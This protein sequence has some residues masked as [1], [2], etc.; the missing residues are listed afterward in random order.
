MSGA[1]TGKKVFVS[2]CHRQGEWVVGSLVPCLRA[3]GVEVWIDVERFKA[4][5]TVI[6]QMDA[7]Q[8]RAEQSLLVFSPDYLAS[9]YCRHEMARAIERDPAFEQG[10]TIPVLVQSCSLPDEIKKPQPLWVDLT[11][12]W[13][14]PNWK[15]L[16][17]ATGAEL[18]CPAARWLETRDELADL[19]RR[20]CSVNFVVP[21]RDAHA[22]RPRWRELLR[23]LEKDRFADL[24]CVDLERGAAA[25]R[26]GLVEMILEATGN[27]QAVP[28]KPHDLGILDRAL[29]K[30]GN[31]A[32]LALIHFDYAVQR[33]DEYGVD[34]FSA[35]RSL[36]EDGHIALMV[37]SC[38]PFMELLPRDHPISEISLTNVE[39]VGP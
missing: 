15:L 8:D 29:R 39:L 18:G 32:K 35:I 7:E 25:A 6:G 5:Q 10:R 34:L 23:H 17:D 31:P 1:R 21:H 20:N 9:E 38:R 36:V 28:A 22:S 3:G 30:P 14:A 13:S 27:K 26:Q 24:C 12:R 33:L 19:L 37:Q 4:G 11:D 16:L 2:Y